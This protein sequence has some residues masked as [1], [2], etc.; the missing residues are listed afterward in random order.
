MIKK[1]S[2]FLA[3]LPM[4]IVGGVFLFFSFI[5]PKFG[6]SWGEYLAWVTVVISGIPL[7]YLA[8]IRIIKNKGISKIS[9]AL[10]ISIAMIAAIIIFTIAGITFL[11]TYKPS[12]VDPIED[13]KRL[14]MNTYIIITLSLVVLTLLAN[15]FSKLREPEKAV[16]ALLS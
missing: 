10:L 2:D 7:L 8:I 6:Y 14:F 3:N 9:S 1:I 5:L 4:T 13:T 11:V 12:V 15:Y 16:V